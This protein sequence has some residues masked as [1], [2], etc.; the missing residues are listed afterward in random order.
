MGLL[1]SFLLPSRKWAEGL[2]DVVSNRV[3]HLLNPETLLEMMEL[4]LT[5]NSVD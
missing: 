2:A 5:A 4:S 3:K 1:E